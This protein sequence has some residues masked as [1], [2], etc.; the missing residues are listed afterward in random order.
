M[1]AEQLLS[2]EAEI[3]DR[4]AES[5]RSRHAFVST[6]RRFARIQLRI[7]GYSKEQATGMVNAIGDG[8]I[9]AFLKQYGPILWKIFLA[10]LPFLLAA[11][12][13]GPSQTPMQYL[14]DEF[15]EMKDAELIG[16]TTSQLL[17]SNPSE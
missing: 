3:N 4:R 17:E 10:I 9:L 11:E 2:I 5:N 6:F 1:T 12:P 7:R 15:D 16:S 8:K 13:G 14:M